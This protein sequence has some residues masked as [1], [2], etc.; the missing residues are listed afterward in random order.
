MQPATSK[1]TGREFHYEGFSPDVLGAQ[2]EDMA[3]MFE[4]F[5]CAAFS[6]GWVFSELH[7][8]GTPAD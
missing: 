7:N 1:V 2:S 5:A 8:P 6:P 3:L 4:W